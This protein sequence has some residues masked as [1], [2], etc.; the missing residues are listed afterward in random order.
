LSQPAKYE[1]GSIAIQKM[2]SQPFTRRMNTGSPCTD[3]QSDET[4]DLM[5]IRYHAAGT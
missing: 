1:I 3:A 5:R 2:A 4:T